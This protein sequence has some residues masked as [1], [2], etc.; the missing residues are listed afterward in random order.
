LLDA[1][2]KFGEVHMPGHEPKFVAIGKKMIT[3]QLRDDKEI[4]G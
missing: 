1:A 2:R 3:Q 4:I